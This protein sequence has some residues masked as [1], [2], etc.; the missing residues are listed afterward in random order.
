MISLL[1]LCTL[2]SHPLYIVA[3]NGRLP[4]NHLG[5]LAT[6]APVRHSLYRLIWS[7]KF[8]AVPDPAWYRQENWL[9]WRLAFSHLKAPQKSGV[10]VAATTI[11]GLMIM[12]CIDPF[13]V[14][15]WCGVFRTHY[16]VPKE[17]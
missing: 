14:C 1:G 17:V 15:D 12:M 4:E 2:L 7:N 5:G 11:Y 8:S 6:G 13:F 3:G 16:D 10:D 9:R